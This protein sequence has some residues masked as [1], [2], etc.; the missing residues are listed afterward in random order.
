MADQPFLSAGGED[1][2][3]DVRGEKRER[4]SPPGPGARTGD[5]G[6]GGNTII[7]PGLPAEAADLAMMAVLQQLLTSN[8]AITARLICLENNQAQ[9]QEQE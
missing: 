6:Q 2:L 9:P 7:S 4:A 1:A 3:L 5:I 8:R